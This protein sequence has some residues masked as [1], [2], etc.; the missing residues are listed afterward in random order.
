MRYRSYRCGAAG[1]GKVCV[2][3][4]FTE[5]LIT[6]AV[7]CRIESRHPTVEY[8]ILDDASDPLGA[9]YDRYTASLNKLTTDYFVRGRITRTESI[10]ARN[11]L[12]RQLQVAGRH[13][14]PRWQSRIRLRNGPSICFRAD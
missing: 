7:L 6:E 9:A 5:R 10:N 8:R 11:G 14:D 1:Y 4:E 12:E 13:L 2:N 3:A